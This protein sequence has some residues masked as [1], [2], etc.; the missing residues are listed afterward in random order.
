MPRAAHRPFVILAAAML[1][2]TCSAKR[3]PI[4]VE[5]STVVVENQSSKDWRNVMVTVNDHFRG[6]TPLL[7]AGS[8]LTAPLTQ[9]QTA[10]GQRFS[11]ERQDVFKIEVTATSSDGQP[12]RL[13]WGQSRK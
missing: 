6:G 1:L 10:Y 3:D 9:F 12:V 5:G 8:R 13:Q 4:S 11:I 7:A 2:G